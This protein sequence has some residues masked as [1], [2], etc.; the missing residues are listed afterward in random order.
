MNFK[1]QKTCYWV[2]SFAAVGS[3]LLYLFGFV[4]ENIS[5]DL[6]PIGSYKL[7]FCINVIQTGVI[8][9]YLLSNGL[10]KRTIEIIGGILLGTLAIEISLGVSIFLFYSQ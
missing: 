4:L 1:Y 8:A 5:I 2:L 3:C 7:F 6:L 10:R 9:T